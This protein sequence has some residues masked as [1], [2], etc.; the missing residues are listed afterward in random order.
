MYYIYF[1]FITNNLRKYNLV[2]M[3]IKNLHFNMHNHFQ[4]CQNPLVF[5]F[6]SYLR[7]SQSL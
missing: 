1:Y 6:K 4:T 7:H 2:I 5:I 3:Y